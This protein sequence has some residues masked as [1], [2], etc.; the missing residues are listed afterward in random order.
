[1]L[2]IFGCPVFSNFRVRVAE[3]ATKPTINKIQASLT[4]HGKDRVS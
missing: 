2:L 3:V 4:A 1:M